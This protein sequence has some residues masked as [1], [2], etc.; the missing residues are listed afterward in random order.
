MIELLYSIDD[1]SYLRWQAEFLEWSV[2]RCGMECRI[3]RLT[4][5]APDA[6]TYL[7]LNRFWSIVH[8]WEPSEIETVVVLDPDMVFVRPLN[9]SARAGGVI[10]QPYSY[11]YGL[12]WCPVVIHRD[13]IRAW[14][15]TA[16]ALARVLYAN[17]V[18]WVS[19]MWASSISANMLGLQ[20]ER[21][22]LCVSN[23]EPALRD[24]SIIHYCYEQAGFFKQRYSPGDELPRIEGTEV[25]QQVTALLR[26]CFGSGTQR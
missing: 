6:G 17:K 7:C 22:S 16:L 19:E 25:Q 4:K 20:L 24:A 12:P 1:S 18:G 15:E 2:R 5:S 26:E 8:Q 23:Y 11:L 10:A 9:V 21:R 14:A 13:Q 3:T